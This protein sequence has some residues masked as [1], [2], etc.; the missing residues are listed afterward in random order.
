MM[1]GISIEW[2]AAAFNYNLAEAEARRAVL[3]A[4]F[5]VTRRMVAAA[6]EAHALIPEPLQGGIRLLALDRRSR[7]VEDVP[8][9]SG[10]LELTA[11]ERYTARE[12]LQAARALAAMRDAA[13]EDPQH[14]AERIATIE[15]FFDAFLAAGVEP[16]ALAEPPAPP[17]IEGAAAE[18]RKAIED[19]RTIAAA[20]AANACPPERLRNP[21]RE[22]AGLID[23]DGRR[24][25]SR[26]SKA[27]N[28]SREDDGMSR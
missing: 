16:P 2:S 3:R 9:M 7:V 11:E 19:A 22:R 24:L 27:A 17:G 26:A 8:I 10:D 12:A 23:G 18:V 13:A 5:P 28:R 15:G 21:M 1:R 4:A 25:R 14:L 6:I 20:D